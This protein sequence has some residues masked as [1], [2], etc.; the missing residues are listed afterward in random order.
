MPLIEWSDIYSVNDS[1]I[2]ERHK[3]FVRLFN[4]M[5]DNYMSECDENITISI[6]DE[7]LTCNILCLTDKEVTIEKIYNNDIERHIYEHNQFISCIYKIKNNIY[8]GSMDLNRAITEFFWEWI[9]NH[10]IKEDRKVTYSQL[11]STVAN[12]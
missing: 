4:K 8:D 9:L 3:N 12:Q 1:Y 5:Y 11:V 10:V 6:I 2:D 7:I